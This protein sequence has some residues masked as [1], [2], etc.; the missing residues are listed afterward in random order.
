MGANKEMTAAEAFPRL[1]ALCAKGEHCQHD[2]LEKMRRWG[3]ADEEQ[4]QVMEKLTGGRYVDDERYARAFV[5]DKIRHG[6]CG[7][8]KIEQALRMKRV[9]DDTV[10]R[11]LDDVDADEYLSALRPLIKQKLKATRATSDYERRMKVTK[12]A[13][14]RGYTFDLIRQCLGTDDDEGLDSFDD[15]GTSALS[16]DDE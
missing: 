12:Y 11:V 9:D 8:R 3:L 5:S 10:A 16:G 13:L 7:R 14:A 2:M 6:R 4:A 1:A 15:D